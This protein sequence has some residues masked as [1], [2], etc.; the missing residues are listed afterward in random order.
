[1]RLL[2]ELALWLICNLT[3]KAFSLK[4]SSNTAVAEWNARPLIGLTAFAVVN[5]LDFLLFFTRA[6]FHC[7]FIAVCFSICPANWSIDRSTN[8]ITITF[9]PL[10]IS[11]WLTNSI[12]WTSCIG[13]NVVCQ[14]SR[15]DWY[16]VDMYFNCSLY[17]IK[18]EKELITSPLVIGPLLKKT[19]YKSLA[20]AFCTNR[21]HVWSGINSN[22]WTYQLDFEEKRPVTFSA[23]SPKI[24]PW[25]A[26]TFSSGWKRG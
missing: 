14:Q 18:H 5:L 13:A 8:D 2:C 22:A 17:T 15:E 4:V 11:A 10:A 1:M 20:I 26:L 19:F 3:D 25:V 6:S 23:H 12:E 9:C 24:R 16:V 7:T 21:L